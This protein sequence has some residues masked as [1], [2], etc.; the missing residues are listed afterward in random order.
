[1]KHR[2][3]RLQLMH[4]YRHRGQLLAEVRHLIPMSAKEREC[5][6]LHLQWELFVRAEQWNHARCHR[7]PTD[8]TSALQ[9]IDRWQAAGSPGSFA[10]RV[11]DALWHAHM[12]VKL[13]MFYGLI[14]LFDLFEMSIMLEA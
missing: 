9:L 13:M 14:W 6:A 12:Q 7:C 10:V 11:T 4:A 5:I 1:M 2:D 3:L 8:P